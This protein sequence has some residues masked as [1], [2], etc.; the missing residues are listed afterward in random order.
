MQQMQLLPS[1]PDHP[2]QE[3]RAGEQLCEDLGKNHPESQLPHGNAL[4]RCPKKN[5][6]TT[7]KDFQTS[8]EGKGLQSFQKVGHIQSREFTWEY[9]DCCSKQVGGYW[10]YC[11]GQ[12]T[13]RSLNSL[14]NTGWIR[15]KKKNGNS[16]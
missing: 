3:Y 8:T 1:I 11:C 16:W 13:L 4:A 15:K 9:T 12:R 6:P 5:H 2:L 7:L 10:K 14:G